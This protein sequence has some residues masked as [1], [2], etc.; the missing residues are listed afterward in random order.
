MVENGTENL[1]IFVDYAA[2]KWEFFIKYKNSRRYLRVIQELRDPA[3][4]I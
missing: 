1:G 3:S 4:E 2:N